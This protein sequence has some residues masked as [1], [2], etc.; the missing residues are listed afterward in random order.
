MGTKDGKGI[1][2]LAAIGLIITTIIWGSAFVVM[3]NSVDIISPTYLLALRFTIAAI[4][5]IL[6]F[7][8]K[9]MKINKSDLFCG[10]LLG[11]FLFVSY[12]FQTYG[13]KYTTASKNAFITTLYVILV[14]FLH[15]FFNHKKPKRNNVI[16]ACIAVVG[17]ALLSLEGDLSINLGDLLTLICG[18]F[19]AVHIVFIDR[20][21]TDHDPVTMTV[22]QMVVAAALSW[23]I[24]PILEGPFDGGV[25]DNTMMIGL[26]YLG[27]FSTMIGFLLQN[28]GQKYLTP[29]TSSILLSFESVFGLI[30]SVIFLGDPLTVRLMAGC[31]FMFAAVILSEYRKKTAS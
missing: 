31:V 10:G 12:F 23:I 6:V 19:Y 4:A 14:P 16:A 22:L 15:W 24:A 2:I 9:V 3:K 20:Y 18:F 8:R 7:W 17:L 26:L 25:I 28:V 1:K 11:V 30:F 27:I 5:L 29:N 21:T 13:L